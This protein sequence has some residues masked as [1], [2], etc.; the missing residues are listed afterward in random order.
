MTQNL[1]FRDYVEIYEY[2]AYDLNGYLKL[3]Q[4]EAQ[5]SMK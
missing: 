5:I 2:S 1:Y 4:F 3:D